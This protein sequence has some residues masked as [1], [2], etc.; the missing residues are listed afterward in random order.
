MECKKSEPEHMFNNRKNEGRKRY[1][2]NACKAL[3]TWSATNMHQDVK[4][5]EISGGSNVH[6]GTNADKEYKANGDELEGFKKKKRRCTI[7]ANGSGMLSKDDLD[8]LFQFQCTEEEVNNV[9]AKSVSAH[10]GRDCCEGPEIELH[11]F[12]PRKG[13]E[14]GGTNGFLK[15]TGFKHIIHQPTDVFCHFGAKNSVVASFV[16]GKD[17][18][19]LTLLSMPCS[20]NLSFSYGSSIKLCF[21]GSRSDA[22]SSYEYT[23]IALIYSA[24]PIIGASGKK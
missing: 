12:Y 1:V 8:L 4:K 20:I 11:S 14:L 17:L 5:A 22:Y 16:S 9:E 3:D 19:C 15:G 13:S 6:E 2:L 24:T 18:F 23:I 10:L 21:T 7:T